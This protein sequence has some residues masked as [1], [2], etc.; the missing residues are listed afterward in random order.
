M[1]SLT[2]NAYDF[3]YYG[4]YNGPYSYLYDAD[5]GYG[6]MTISSSSQIAYNLQATNE[7]S[8]A[9]GTT[10]YSYS[11]SNDV[12]TVEQ[13]SNDGK[14]FFTAD[15]DYGVMI[16]TQ[17]SYSY[18]NAAFFMGEPDSSVSN[19]TLSGDYHLLFYYANHNYAY[20]SAYGDV[21]FSGNGS[22]Y[23]NIQ[24]SDSSTGYGT[25][26]NLTYSIASDGKVTAYL[27]NATLYG[28]VDG[29]GDLVAL[30]SMTSGEEQV[31][32]MAAKKSTSTP[33]VIG[34]DYY[35]MG[36]YDT[37]TY[38]ASSSVTSSTFS[39]SLIKGSDSDWASG[40]SYSLS[41]DGYVVVD[42]NGQNT[43][44]GF[45]S[46]D[47]ELIVL[48]D[49]DA[50]D[51]VLG[52]SYF[53]Q[54]QPAQSGNS[55]PT[56]ISL[57]KP[58]IMEDDPGATV[59]TLSAQD[60]D[61]GDTH[62]FSLITD[63][64][65]LFEISG[66]TLKLKSNSSADY[67]TTPIYTLTVRATDASGA[68]YDE[69]LTIYI[70]DLEEPA[71]PVDVSESTWDFA[72]NKHTEGVVLVDSSVTGTVYNNNDKDWFAVSLTAGTTYLV[73]LEGA[74]TNKGTLTN[75][76]FAGV[77]NSSENYI[78]GTYDGNSGIGLNAQ[79]SFTPFITDTYYL[80]ASSA[81]S[82]SSG[83]Y[84][85]SISA[86]DSSLTS[87]HSYQSII[88]DIPDNSETDIDFE[89][90]ATTLG[91]LTVG[92]SITGNIN[93]SQ[94]V[95]WF[96]VNLDKDV[97][98]RLTIEK[99]PI[100]SSGTFLPYFNGVYGSQG[101]FIS[102]AYDTAG[103]PTANTQLNFTPD[104]SGTYYVAATAYYQT[105][106]YTLSV[107][108]QAVVSSTTIVD[109]SETDLDFEDSLTTL[110]GITVGSYITGTIDSSDDK[111][112]FAV[113]LTAGTTYR[114]DLEGADSSKGS[115]SNPTLAGIYDASGSYQSQSYDGNSG[116]GY[117]AQESFTPSV[118]GTY[119][120]SA[121]GSGSGSY[122]LSIDTLSNIQASNSAP[123]DIALSAT[124]F[125]E[126]SV[127][128]TIATLS[129][130]D[131]DTGDQLSFSLMTDSSGLFEVDGT[132]LKLKASSMADY[133]SASSHSVTILAT[134][135]LGETYHE[136]FTLSVEDLTEASALVDNAESITD[137]V[138]SVA[139]L[140]SVVVG[141]SVTGT[142]SSSN[143]HDWFAVSLEA[144]KTYR[145][146]L[147]GSDTSKGTLSNPTLYGIFDSAGSY[148]SK[149]Y[150]GNSGTGLNAQ[151]SFTP[152]SDG[153][154]YL[155]AGSYG[156]GS[157]TLSVDLASNLS[158]SIS[159]NSES[160][161]DFAAST[162]TSG[163][164]T[165]GSSV[166]GT[167]GSA[168]DADWFAVTLTAGT[169]YQ[170]DL[171][172]A[173]SS[174]G[175]LSNPTLFGIF[176][177]SGNYISKSYDGNSGS[178]LNAQES[179]TPTSD[180]TYYLSAGSYGTGSY[181]LS[182]AEQSATVWSDVSETT[183]DLPATSSTSGML[184]LDSS[185]TGTVDAANDVDWFAVNLS[186]G[187][188]YQVDLQGAD[189]S[190]GTL[191]NPTLFGIFDSSGSFV[192]KSYDGN[193]GTGFDAQKSFTPD[194]DGV[195]YLAAGS[196][197]T[198]S[199]TLSISGGSSSSSGDSS[200][201]STTPSGDDYSAS[202]ATTGELSVGGSITGTVESANDID[203]FAV[204]LTAGTS[205]QIDL[206][207]ADSSKGTLANPTLYGIYDSSGGFVSGSFDANSGSGLN[208]Q[209]TLT[210][211]TSGTYYLAAGSHVTGTYALSVEAV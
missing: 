11:T 164:I 159:D 21:S 145:V 17:N 134:D 49:R 16:N 168:N 35:G 24:A 160:T 198:G 60:N 189:S 194:S 149:S 10:N 166:T 111:D 133:E 106:S 76:T 28:M 41:S 142:V 101:D 211:I 121:S 74:D 161:T 174:K 130:T 46:Q 18:A 103:G 34:N 162:S 129:A 152:T 78:D 197:V 12:I 154:Y 7:S 102:I 128:A 38:F 112:W 51:N 188:A 147:E 115:L 4:V 48:M 66:T 89:A 140:G 30:A 206:E 81:T 135:S 175:T 207:G 104:S 56:D 163:G 86:Q 195:Y 23:L 14:A 82:T 124:S 141:S 29:D 105:G 19:S 62:T 185:V 6:E 192:S 139:T 26:A 53:I 75:P 55:T 27:D 99:L 170:I 178:G 143:D 127:G 203:W 148:L 20:V 67:E 138:A 181:T 187:V 151:E 184:T 204:A 118:S 150:D 47:G 94:D 90:A 158:V 155:S 31:M 116:S 96:A 169:T 210:P 202:S 146:D 171:E 1:M 132:T 92:S 137:F 83:T 95:D 172:G 196:H 85:L 36:I 2:N 32:L 186:A 165:V 43:Q 110:G 64:S 156:T 190:K 109:N 180:G 97:N 208:A 182:I 205:Y 179:F 108:A 183:S 100:S 52:F 193:S 44:Y 119:Y 177:S 125:A 191:S 5:A 98:Y 200:G 87:N 61:A 69:D 136:T 167:V 22:G 209:E 39:S 50:S 84:T 80:S 33:D 107:A 70:I 123:T 79:T 9:T 15:G 144:G 91:G 88:G 153:T 117:N 120:L 57:S 113:S 45:V 25:S 201:G 65:G 176:D 54:G 77:Y 73:K 131:G 59:G 122:T 93:N 126:N 173:D 157:Y 68:S 8:L 13:G 58:Y 63:S 114:I 3:I 42:P 199:Y 37:S 40:G 72:A 71:I